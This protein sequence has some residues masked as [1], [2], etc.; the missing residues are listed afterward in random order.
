MTY[1][2]MKAF[3]IYLTTDMSS[4]DRN[5]TGKCRDVY[6]NPEKKIFVH[7]R[8]GK[9]RL[10]Y[11]SVYINGKNK[12]SWINSNCIHVGRYEVDVN[13]FWIIEDMVCTEIQYKH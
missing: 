2:E 10:N 1:K 6:Y 11:C 8:V 5:H 3:A 9:K 12:Q 7:R 13:P 4:E